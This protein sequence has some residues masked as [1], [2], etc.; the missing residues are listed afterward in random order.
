MITLPIAAAMK[1]ISRNFLLSTIN[2][3]SFLKFLPPYLNVTHVTS[4]YAVSYH[5]IGIRKSQEF[6]YLM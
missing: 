2:S 6:S 4:F 1:M 3:A 5:N